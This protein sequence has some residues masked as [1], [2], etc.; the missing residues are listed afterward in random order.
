MVK[1]NIFQQVRDELDDF[2]TK[3][4]KIGGAVIDG[5]PVGGFD[6]SQ[7]ET[8]QNIEFADNS[9]FVTGE[10]DS[11]GQQKFYLNIASFRKEVA[12]KNIDIDVKNFNFVP[13]DGQQPYETALA[14]KR[15]RRWAKDNGL[16]EDINETT[17]RFPKYGHIVAKRVGKEFEIVPL[18]KLRN[19]QD[20]EC[21]EKASYVIEEHSDLGKHEL[22]DYKGWDTSKL[23]MKWNDKV[24]VYERYG[25][26]PK[27]F[28]SDSEGEQDEEGESVYAM[29]VVTLEKG[30]D[31]KIGGAVLFSEEAECPYI[32]QAYAK[33]D[34]R[35]LG[36]GEIEKQLDN[37]AA[38]NMIFNLRKK[39]LAWSAKNIF[40]TA[41]DTLVNNLVREVK[42]GDVLKISST[43]NGLTRVDTMNRANADFN[44]IDQLVEENSN[45]RSFTFEVATGESM[46]SGTPFRLGALLGNSVNSYYDKKR[47]SLGIFWKKIVMEFMIPAWIKE[48]DEEFIETLVESDEDFEDLREAKKNYL[49]GRKITES[50]LSTG[51]ANVEEISQDVDN[52][53]SKLRRDDFKMFKERLKSLKYR[54]D[55]DI[56]GESIDIPK[57]IETLT[58]LYQ[59]Q[60]QMQDIEG[61]KATVK[62]ILSLTGEKMPRSSAPTPQIGAMQAPTQMPTE[63]APVAPQI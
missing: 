63:T 19:Q 29:V 43:A 7:W 2:F 17:E 40:Q 55:L 39:T 35:W 22:A 24:T 37:Q 27:S 57:K 53:L 6:Y 44:S 11:E 59:A 38:R 13:E 41:D 47:E 21:L 36:I 25:Y 12:S 62:K 26:V 8:L 20:A 50:L 9:K 51:N 23:K 45:Q 42:D 15:F 18:I 54:L 30:K 58:N 48:T 28:L 31:G 33:Q 5:K 34:G 46:A 32:E 56:T 3:K 16:S 4:V 14:R 52:E 10:I 1:F 49:I 60:L 61:A